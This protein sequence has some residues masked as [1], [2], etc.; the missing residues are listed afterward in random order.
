MRIGMVIVQA[1]TE[2]KREEVSE[3]R[4]CEEKLEWS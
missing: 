4:I 2:A 3:L 1:I